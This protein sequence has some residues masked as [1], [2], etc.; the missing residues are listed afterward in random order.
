[1]KIGETHS[2]VLLVEFQI[3]SLKK[4]AVKPEWIWIT[5]NGIT[6]PIQ[7]LYLADLELR[8]GENATGHPATVR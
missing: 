3:S 6:K 4:E 5:Q 8:P 1:M 2:G 7:N